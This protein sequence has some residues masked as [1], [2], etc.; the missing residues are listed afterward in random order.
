MRHTIMF[1]LAALLASPAPAATSQDRLAALLARREP[2]PPRRCIFPDRAVQP[3]IIAGTGIVYRDARYVYVGRFKGGCPAL[4][5]GRTIITRSLGGQLC[6][7][8]PVRVV[9]STGADFGFCTFE[10]F[11]P[12]RKVK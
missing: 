9:E 6:E 12:Y 2:D 1:L 4:R 8:D 11:T 5:E 7:N 3:Q 10:N